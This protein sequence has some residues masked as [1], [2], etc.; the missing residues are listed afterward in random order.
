MGHSSG[1]ESEYNRSKVRLHPHRGPWL[2]PANDDFL[3]GDGNSKEKIK[4]L[5]KWNGIYS[6]F[7]AE[8]AGS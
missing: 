7:N 3:L 8:L 1:V 6:W 2:L 5:D 4:S